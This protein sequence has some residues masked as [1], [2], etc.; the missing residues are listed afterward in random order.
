MY[1]DESGFEAEAT[2]F[3]MTGYTASPEVWAVFGDLW[4]KVLKGYGVSEFHSADFFGRRS[5]TRSHRN[6]Y[7]GWSHKK[8]ETFLGKL[9][10]TIKGCNLYPTGV[11]VDLAAF[12]ERC[13]GE[14]RLLTGGI[15]G[16]PS[17]SGHRKWLTSGAPSKPYF[18]AFQWMLREG[19][20]LA[21]RAESNLR[22]GGVPD[23]VKI[24]FTFDWQEEY[25]GGAK[26]SFADFI[27]IVSPDDPLPRRLGNINYAKRSNHPGLQAADLF[28]FGWASF[29]RQGDEMHA[30]RQF[31]LAN[32]SMTNSRIR[33]INREGMDATFEMMWQTD[34]GFRDFVLAT[35]EQV[36][37]KSKRGTET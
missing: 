16:P 20:A 36:R 1:A 29:M 11:A 3:I 9:V 10:G 8:I 13:I 7:E 28:T 2:H 30:E 19:M 35:K 37:N 25:E 6:I 27:R 23:G 34:T 26:A 31:V 17:K 22:L 33:L 14:R 18:A 32:L 12:R 4:S 5:K 21:R 15:V 24:D